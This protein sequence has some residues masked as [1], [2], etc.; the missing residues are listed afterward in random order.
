VGTLQENVGSVTSTAT[1]RPFFPRRIKLCVYLSNPAGQRAVFERV[2]N[3]PAGYGRQ[4]SSGYN[5]EHFSR[6]SA[7]DYFWLY[8]DDPSGLDAD[9]DAAACEHLSGPAPGPPIPPEPTPPPQ[10]RTTTT[11]TCNDGIDSDGDGNIDL[12]DLEYGNAYGF[13]SRSCDQTHTSCLDFIDNDRDGTLDGAD[14]DV[15]GAGGVSAMTRCDQVKPDVV[16]RKPKR[17]KSLPVRLFCN[18]IVGRRGR[19]VAYRTRAPRRCGIWRPGWVDSQGLS[20]IKARWTHWGTTTARARVTITAH[21]FRARA[22]LKAYR[23]RRD[24][25]RDY[26]VYTRVALLPTG[27]RKRAVVIKPEAC[28][29]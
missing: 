8:P 20:F 5:C 4:R 11:D 6:Y 16:R 15:S 19:N 17:H 24:C 2:V 10:P 14:A 21:G 12:G 1:F 28:P 25:T 27:K 3:I 13:P 29:G 7:Q 9:N 23:L 26:R 18:R 22:R